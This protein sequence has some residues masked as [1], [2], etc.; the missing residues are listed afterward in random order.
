M[1][2][3]NTQW[4]GRPNS[5]GTSLQQCCCRTWGARRAGGEPEMHAEGDAGGA[6]LTVTCVWCAVMVGVCCY[7]A[8]L[9]MLMLH[10]QTQ[11]SESGSFTGG[12]AAADACV[13]T[14][15]IG[16]RSSAVQRLAECGAGACGA[17]THEYAS[18]KC[19]ENVPYAA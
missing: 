10:L 17:V 6:G 7:L 19:S 5:W 4:K 2:G 12:A 16:R 14:L 1:E 9:K 13:C 15:G 8:L 11:G 3:V 18:D